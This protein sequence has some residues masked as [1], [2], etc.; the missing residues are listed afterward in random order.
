MWYKYSILF[1]LGLF[2]S[3][4]LISQTPSYYHYS[5]SNGLASSTVFKIIQDKQG[6]IWV[7]TLNGVCRFDG[8]RFET[9]KA[10]D[11]LNSNSIVTL[12]NGT[13]GE[14]YAGSYENG[15]SIIKN[16]SIN[17]FCDSINNTKFFTNDLIFYSLGKNESV[18]YTASAFGAINIIKQNDKI[19]TT[20]SISL[21]PIVLNRLVKSG[22][23]KVMA[24]TTAGI[25]ELYYKR[26]SKILIEGLPDIS[27][28]CLARNSEGKLF[29]GTKG[30]I[31]IVDK[32]KVSK[33][34][35]VSSF[36][37]EE[38]SN[39]LCDSQGNI[40][41]SIM[42]NGFFLIPAGSERIIDIGSKMN[43]Q[44]T[45]VNSYLEDREGN[46]W[47]ST[48]G[49]G[50][51]CLNHLYINSYNES[52][53]LINNSVHAIC[54]VGNG[55]FAI[56]TFNGVC[57]FENGSFTRILNPINKNITEYIYSIKKFDNDFF[58]CGA[59]GNHEIASNKHRDMA[60]YFY[61]RPS[62]HK[63]GNGTFLLGTIS[64]NIK[65][66]KDI[67][68]PIETNLVIYG[69][70]MR[71]NRIYDIYE[72]SGQNIWFGTNEG[73]C[74]LTAK[75]K[76]SILNINYS[77]WEKTF[78]ETN[79][80]LRSRIKYIFQDKQSKVWFG[81]EKGIAS[82]NLLNDSINTFE[83]LNGYDLAASTSISQDN[84]NRIW[85]GNMNGLYI[86]DGKSV[87]FLN[88]NT[89]LPSNEV[90]SLSYDSYKNIMS[91]GTSAG[92]S[93]IDLDLFDKFIEPIPEVKFLSISAGDLTSKNFSN[94]IY[95]PHQNNIQVNFKA[96]NYSSPASIKYSYKLNNDNWNETNYDFLNYNSLNYGKYILHV[97]AKFQNSEWGEPSEINFEIKPKFFETT[98]FRIILLFILTLIIISIIIYRSKRKNEK[99]NAELELTKR[100]NE[101]KHQALSAMMNPH[102]IFNALNSLQYLINSKKTKEANEYL[103]M[104]A[105]LIRK[106]LD[107]AGNGFILLSDEIARLTIYLDLEKLRFQ[108]GFTYEIIRG[109]D[110]NP[111]MILIPNMI[112]QPFVENSLWHGILTSKDKGLITV[113]FFF[114]DI[115][116]DLVVSKYLIIKVSDNGVGIT[117][118]R[119]NKKD[120]H[121]SK[122]IQIIEE[123]F[124]LLSEKMQ[125]P[126]PIMFEELSAEDSKSN[127]TQVIVSLPPALYKLL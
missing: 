103:A 54:N 80:V 26:R 19:L 76:N 57:I 55:R 18:V 20:R 64:N 52:D 110:I 60:F 74:K 27:I 37:N 5:T 35:D 73:V 11:G 70:S 31:W 79:P 88:Q 3:F 4:K 47:I 115:D 65:I 116:I 40:W 101:L 92:I 104:M 127:G 43:L 1:L 25:F 120:E 108:D 21:H 10:K 100:I 66:T 82:Y 94:L 69:D 9:F 36:K 44:K 75:S 33:T 49:K 124:R 53:G 39:I 42:H 38:V 45:V 63:T 113:S 125:L 34:Y 72:D 14:I 111:D 59:F 2:I 48:M 95:E 102:F 112:I 23:Y 16:D 50:I 56:G 99:F 28:Q 96:L 41:F 7:A 77:D 84:K 121:V 22:N 87:K 85:I 68:N 15:I 32:F 122:G 58:I 118:A 6:F 30:K 83:K 119:K 90:L 105:W 98:A 126:S 8:T 71:L 109:T 114:E 51:F 67:G 24:L 106:N 62:I 117:E 91:V 81:G 12:A 123:R 86:Y 13:N 29:I 61:N 89:G 107:T 78:Y 46:I 97:K 17:N 93:F